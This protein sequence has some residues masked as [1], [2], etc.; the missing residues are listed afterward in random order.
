M[1]AL[2]KHV[3]I[4]SGVRHTVFLCTVGEHQDAGDWEQWQAS[5]EAGHPMIK[6]DEMVDLRS[7]CVVK[8]VQHILGNAP[9]T[10]Q[11]AS[12][13]WA[14]LCSLL[15]TIAQTTWH[16][17]LPEHLRVDLEGI[18]SLTVVGSKMHHS[19]NAELQEA[20]KYKNE[21]SKSKSFSRLLSQSTS[22]TRLAS[23]VLD[24]S[25]ACKAEGGWKEDLE[26]ALQI[27]S[28]VSEFEPS[29]LLTDEFEVRIPRASL[30]AD[31]SNK[32]G[33]LLQQSTDKFQSE[34]AKDIQKVKDFQLGTA[35]SIKK[36]LLQRMFGKVPSLHDALR[37][38]ATAHDASTDVIG[39]CDEHIAA[40]TSAKKLCSSVKSAVSKTVGADLGSSLNEAMS[41]CSL[42]LDSMAG[43]CTWHSDF[44]AFAA[45]VTCYMLVVQ[46]QG[47]CPVQF[48]FCQVLCCLCAVMMKWEL[49]TNYLGWIEGNLLFVDRGNNKN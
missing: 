27:A 13:S 16:E 30:I 41:Q 34:S 11:Q 42:L 21:I 38:C 39:K 22:G 37:F 3:K 29:L 35:L 23:A 49:T 45:L 32:L 44:S 7:T 1:S 31:M 24:V 15:T 4:A 48:H 14:A 47:C 28:G 17:K 26:Q 25:A 19:S 10:P 18:K 8:C 5:M 40:I 9:D 20:E 12:E 36:A 43:F 33:L 2:E 6:E 46:V